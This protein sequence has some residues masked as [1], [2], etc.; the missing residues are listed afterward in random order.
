MRA[1]TIIPALVVA[2]SMPNDASA[3]PSD[4][5]GY[6]TDDD[7]FLY[8]VFNMP[9][10]DQSRRTSVPFGAEGL[11]NDGRLHCGPT[12]TTNVLAWI[13]N[14]GYPA[15]PQGPDHWE[16]Y[17]ISN[18][19]P[20]ARE[21]YNDVTGY[22]NTIAQPLYLN[23]DPYSAGTVG[24]MIAIGV[25]RY[26]F[27][28]ALSLGELFFTR[29]SGVSG[30]S[31]TRG[32]RLIPSIEDAAYNGLQG[33]V[34]VMR[35]G[36]Y[37]TSD[38][39]DTDLPDLNV[40]TGGHLVAVTCIERR[41]GV[42]YISFTNSGTGGNAE[43]NQSE[44]AVERHRVEEIS[45]DDLN[46]GTV[47]RQVLIPVNKTFDEIIG[48]RVK[49]IDEFTFIWP[50][51]GFSVGPLETE[52]RVHQ[53][54]VDDE[55]D[56]SVQTWTYP[57]PTNTTIVTA[58]AGGSMRD[59]FAVTTPPP[60]SIFAAL[61]HFDR[62]TGTWES[63]KGAQFPTEIAVTRQGTVLFLEGFV[64]PQGSFLTH[65][66]PNATGS[67]VIAEKFLFPSVALTIDDEND[68]VHVLRAGAIDAIDYPDL[69][70]FTTT[71][72]PAGTPWENATGFAISPFDGHFWLAIGG[73]LYELS[74]SDPG[75][76]PSYVTHSTVEPAE[77]VSIDENGGI[78]VTMFDGTSRIAER[79]MKDG[80]TGNLVTTGSSPFSGLG[81]GKHFRIS[82]ST[83]SADPTLFLQPGSDDLPV[84]EISD[85]FA[86]PEPRSPAEVCGLVDDFENLTSDGQIVTA[87]TLGDVEITLSNATGA[88]FRARTY[89]SGTRAFQGA[90]DLD[91]APYTST[92]VSGDWFISTTT[93]G[94]SSNGL[95][96]VQPV[97]FDLSQPVR[98]FAMTTTD[99]HETGS[100]LT[101]LYLR[102]YDAGG[103][104][105]AEHTRTG[106]K[107]PSGV[108]L[109][110]L[111][112]SNLTSISRVEFGAT[113]ISCC[114]GFGIDDLAICFG[115]CLTD[116]N[117]DG[118]TSVLDFSVF[119]AA[120]TTV[121]LPP[122]SPGDFDGD[123][124]V[125]IFDFA[126]FAADF[127][128]GL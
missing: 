55:G 72:L 65:I 38:V 42:S 3:Q 41:G 87:R 51:Q 1:I 125:D 11:P 48:P 67:P 79:F 76:E 121:E 35:Y 24:G 53:V 83:N 9:D 111:V 69:T 25:R 74:P 112:E 91:N 100:D 46:G 77:D 90:D 117:G 96:V 78:Y 15:L 122:Y 4:I 58:D 19:C 93:S 103:S 124:D 37:T 92:A 28:Q 61:R 68:T 12:S 17:T 63:I 54:T 86:E 99:L 16:N 23:T 34:M 22:I 120:F 126:I 36:Y 123:G 115:P 8:S 85:T 88:P 10:F 14:H 113:S 62:V 82:R 20:L 52:M 70:S 106:V 66:D 102:A 45:F 114:S 26:L 6:Y 81:V 29:S 119:A 7:N 49:M 95:D 57:A 43:T 84:D 108:V 104:L 80:L 89:N 71:P 128:C 18:W 13:A 27:H 101:T 94:G 56:P 33:A 116:L 2:L 47:T 97:T 50:R 73:I 98:A 110:W 107:G 39:F 109:H 40:R 127:Q 31:W 59:I 44:F 105:V 118:T 75:T 64:E 21:R 30:G 5:Q 60:G 32:W